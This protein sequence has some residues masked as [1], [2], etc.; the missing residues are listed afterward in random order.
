MTA[1]RVRFNAMTL[2][3]SYEYIYVIFII[4]EIPLDVIIG[5]SWTSL[6]CKPSSFLRSKQCLSTFLGKLTDYLPAS[7]QH[8]DVDIS[9][10]TVM[11]HKYCAVCF[12]LF[13]IFRTM[14]SMILYSDFF[15]VKIW[16]DQV[17]R[18]EIDRFEK[19]QGIV[20]IILKISS[21]LQKN[22]LVSDS[23][24]NMA[25]QIKS[26]RPNDAQEKAMAPMFTGSLHP[27]DPARRSG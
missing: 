1:R 7:S 13:V 11:K 18:G 14:F 26:A 23:M 19:A 9:Q 5:E 27:Y 16:L 24:F 3:F 8:A 4:L 12:S 15:D 22:D 6:L 20:G 10:A 17:W 2:E 21:K 25:V